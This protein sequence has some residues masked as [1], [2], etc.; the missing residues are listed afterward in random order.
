MRTTGF[1]ADT[2]EDAG[3]TT[4]EGPSLAAAGIAGLGIALPSVDDLA[5]PAV[6]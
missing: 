4:A 1:A 2:V 3:P 5:A 6:I